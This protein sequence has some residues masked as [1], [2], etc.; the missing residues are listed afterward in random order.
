[1]RLAVDLFFPI[2]QTFSLSFFSLFFSI[3]FSH[4]EYFSY[5]FLSFIKITK[6]A[7]FVQCFQGGITM[8]LKDL[9]E[10]YDNWNN[11]TRVNDDELNVIV[12]M[13]TYRLYDTRK[14]LLS[15]EVVAFG[16]YDDLFTVRIKDAE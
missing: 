10:M 14:D 7:Q 12:Q 4:L 3:I 1:M 13:P 5:I 15:C 16:F 8:T 11:E 6:V 2:S 9:L